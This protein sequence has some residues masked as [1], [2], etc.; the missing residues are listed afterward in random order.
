MSTH[1]LDRRPRPMRRG[2]YVLPSLFTMGNVL[3]GFYAVVLAHRGD[4]DRAPWMIIIAGVLDGLDGRI[5]RLTHT[6]SEFGKELDSLADVLTFG[7]A[8]AYIGY[9]WGLHEHGRVG[10]LIPVLFLLCTAI[11]L[12]RFNVQVRTVDSRQFVGLPSPAAAG[13]LMALLFL[14]LQ[15][16]EV[17][18]W[19][20]LRHPVMAI[21]LV[22]AGALMVSTFRYPSFKKID[23]RRR[24]SYR[25]AAG[26]AVLLLL[27][28]SRPVIAFQA[29]A[30]GF[31]LSGPLVWLF[32]RL[33][34]QLGE[35]EA[36]TTQD[37]PPAPA[38]S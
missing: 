23:L 5:A 25:T 14:D 11:R 33:R 2:A 9:L 13:T 34:R 6:E 28:L 35:P 31:A 24:W 19:Q 30:V 10:W 17:E 18:P 29:L 27:V 3:L 37:D 26:T 38:V 1:D 4:F 32:G 15:L 20:D 12:A 16:A 7:A 21:T 36:N 8:P 22:V